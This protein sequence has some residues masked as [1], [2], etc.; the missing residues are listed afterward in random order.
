MK[1]NQKMK[2]ISKNKIDIEREDLIIIITEI[3]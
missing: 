3:I 2:S 1:L